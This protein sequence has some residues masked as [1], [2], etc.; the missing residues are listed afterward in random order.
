MNKVFQFVAAAVC[1]AL[2]G[3]SQAVPYEYPSVP[4]H[5][6]PG[7]LKEAYKHEK[8]NLGDIGRCVVAYDSSVAEEKMIFTCSIYVKMSAVAER[9]AMERCEGLRASKGIKGP[10][11]VISE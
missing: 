6:I 11:R 7:P 3:T 5:D 10:C 9:K 1:S 2:V 4:L 8:P